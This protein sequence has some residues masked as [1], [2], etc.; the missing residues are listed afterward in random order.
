MAPPSW[1]GALARPLYRR[2]QEEEGWEG[3][4]WQEGERH[5]RGRSIARVYVIHRK[6]IPASSDTPARR[7][8]GLK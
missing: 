2:A 5:S 8:L 3:S 1:A 6:R 4:G 7:Q